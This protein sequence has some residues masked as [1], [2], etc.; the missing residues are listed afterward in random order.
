MK[1][2][3]FVMIFVLGWTLC[4]LAVACDLRDGFENPPAEA[5]P[6]VYWYFIDG[7]QDRDQMIADLEAMKT[8]GLG[9]V[10]F[11]EVD[12]AMPRGPVAFM[13]PQW[14]ENVTDAFIAAEKMGIEVIFGAGPGWAGSGGSWVATDDSM[15]HLVGSSLSVSGPAVFNGKLKVPPAHPSNPFSGLNDRQSARR[16]AWYQD[17]AVI[18]LP[19]P[20]KGNAMIEGVDLKTLKDVPPY[21]IRRT[22]RRYIDPVA[23][24]DEPPMERVIDNTKIIDLTDSMQPDGTIEWQVPAGDW[25]IMRFVARST[26]QTTRPAPRTGHGFENNKFDGG[27]FERHWDNFQSKLIE[28]LVAKGGKLGGK[29]GLTT[30]H[31]DSWEMSSQNWTAGF[32]HEFQKRRSYDPLPYFPAYMGQV[33]GS[34]EQTERFLWDVRKTAQELVLEQYVGAIKRIAGDHSLMYSNQ[35]YDMN[36]AG[37]LDLGALADVPMGEFW[38]APH[39]SQYSCIEATSIAHTMGQQVVKAEAFTSSEDAFRKTPANMK[40]QT[41]WAFAIGINGIVFH[42]FAH[43]CFGDRAKPGMTMGRYGIQ[44]H[45]NQTFWDFLPAYHQYIAR[46]SYLLRR[47]EAVA[48]ILYLTPEGAPHIFAPPADAT[49]GDQRM[50]DKKGYSFDGVSPRMLAARAFV[51]DGRIAFPDGS[52]YRILVL[53]DSPTMTPEFLSFVGTLL[54]NGATVVGSPPQA[55]PSLVNYPLCDQQVVALAASIWGDDANAPRSRQ[56]IDVGKGSLYWGGELKVRQDLYPSYGATA[57]LLSDLQVPE[58]FVSPSRKLRFIHRQTQDQHIYFV[59]N[60]TDGRVETEGVFRVSGGQP[61]LWNPI[62][63]GTRTLPDYE[64]DGVQTRVPLVLEPHQSF[65][66]VFPKIH[67]PAESPAESKLA[68]ASNF[69]ALNSIQAI[70]G[71][72]NVSFDPRWGGPDNVDFDGLRDWALHPSDAIRHY[73]GIATY[74]KTFQLHSNIDDPKTRTYLDLGK[75]RDLCRVQINGQDLGVLWTTPFRVEVTDAIK[76]GHNRL[77]IEVVNTWANRLIG[78]AALPDRSQYKFSHS[79][80][81]QAALPRWIVDKTLPPAGPRKT[82]VTFKHFKP[83]DTLSSSGLIGPVT[84]LQ[85][86]D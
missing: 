45:R 4:S 78:D 81:T 53:P 61:E 42:T 30:I 28:K 47:G 9:S 8:V 66:V 7:N 43:Q 17:V 79:D 62:H 75:V 13:T 36:P 57:K 5:R 67:S 16:D 49:E 52:K 86:K 63:G 19:T 65:F 20:P 72:W 35:P 22:Q 50:G 68:A 71:R 70:D 51:E 14:Q 76:T 31:L 38:N 32:G 73:S 69:P 64:V 18:A 46:C 11:L 80:K 3:F 60:R 84:I 29:A 82:F 26:G 24:Y 34:R 56:R 33:V 44:W 10:I 54:E 83:G 25:T 48:D 85:A 55:S 39:D 1:N 23:D 74:R 27:S 37:D 15:Q 58:D 6:G 12:L 59:S 21:S 77:E 41:D 40:N 2:N